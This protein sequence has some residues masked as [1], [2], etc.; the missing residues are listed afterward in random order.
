MKHKSIKKTIQPVQ[1]IYNDWITYIKQQ[2]DKIK[3]TAQWKNTSQ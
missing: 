2:N 1:P 3:N